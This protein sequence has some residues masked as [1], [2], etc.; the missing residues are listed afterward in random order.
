MNL[1][2]LLFLLLPLFFIGLFA[3][4][5]AGAMGPPPIACPNLY[6]DTLTQASLTWSGG[7]IDLLAHPNVTIALP[8]SAHYDVSLTVRT[9]AN[10]TTGNTQPGLVWLVS[11]NQGFPDSECYS[12]PYPNPTNQTIGP[13]QVVRLTFVNGFPC[14]VNPADA[15]NESVYFMTVTGGARAINNWTYASVRFNTDW[16]GNQTSSSSSSSSSSATLPTTTTS[17]SSS[18][19]QR[20]TTTSSTTYSS[21]TLPSVT[22]TTQQVATPTIQTS[23]SF[24]TSTSVVTSVSTQT[25]TQTMVTNS[26]TLST[27]TQTQTVTESYPST[28]ITSNSSSSANSS[29]LSTFS[30]TES[31]A[32]PSPSSVS[33]SSSSLTTGY[34]TSNET[35]TSTTT[36]SASTINYTPV[37]YAGAAVAIASGAIY[38]AYRYLG[39][40]P[41]TAKVS[42]A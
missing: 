9:A 24:I 6:A 31:S 2:A 22:T 42:T 25:L 3:T 12:G 20:T 7:T 38:G 15:I 34:T 29:F 17:S 13:D 19:V 18:T 30:S 26:A 10:S 37:Y 36:A 27:V 39:R 32:S 40:T 5:P 41:K 33:Q 11:D 35:S 4:A 16:T 1:R 21:I 23:T 28:V 14:C 8:N